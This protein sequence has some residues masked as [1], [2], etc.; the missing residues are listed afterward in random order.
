MNTLVISVYAQFCFQNGLE[1][2][3]NVTTHVLP[4]TGCTFGSGKIAVEFISAGTSPVSNLR[5]RRIVGTF[6]RGGEMSI[7]WN[8]NFS[9][10]ISRLVG[11]LSVSSCLRKASWMVS[12]FLTGGGVGSFFRP[13]FGFLNYK[14]A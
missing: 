1:R 8:L 14:L 6:S 5:A 12:P 11:D 4:N 13:R 2:F 10:V 3:R 7:S 9:G